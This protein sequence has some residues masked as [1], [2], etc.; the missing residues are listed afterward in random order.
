MD[1][2]A[3]LPSPRTPRDYLALATDPRVDVEGLRV[4]ARNPFSF[5]RLAV[6]SNIRSDASVLTELLTG[7]FSQWDRNRLLWIVAGH[8][9]AGRVV[10]LNVLSQVALLLAQRDVRPYAAAIALASRPELT[11]NEVRRLQNLPGASRRMRRGAERAIARRSG[12]DVGAASQDS[13]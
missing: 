7:E 2:E 11:P 1:I 6:A 5:V 8:P 12:R 9:Q 4:L 13:A 10:L 3:L